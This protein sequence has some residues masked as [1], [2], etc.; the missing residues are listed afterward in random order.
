MSGELRPLGLANGLLLGLVL[1]APLIA[2]GL[3][4]RGVEALFILSAFQLRLVDRRWA[5]RDGWRGWVSHIRMAPL[6][7]APWAAT[8]VV[9]LIAHQQALAEAI[10]SAAVLSE[11]LVYPICAH[12]LGRLPRAGLGAV[13][14]LTIAASAAIAA[15]PLRLIGGFVTGVAGCVFWLRGPDGEVRNLALAFAGTLLAIGG[16]IAL[17]QLW[18]FA[19]PAGIACAVL[20]LAHLSILRRRPTPW[21]SGDTTRI[22]LRFTPRR[23]APRLPPA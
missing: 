12:L 17:P 14:L 4:A 10:L 3:M 16:A 22:A 21:H 2:P 19:W 18:P 5:L 23:S 6:R 1:A 8:A 11:L 20:T 7:L 13:A 9:A 15:E